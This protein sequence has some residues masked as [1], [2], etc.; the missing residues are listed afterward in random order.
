MILIS[1]MFSF[2]SSYIFFYDI[3]CNHYLCWQ[4]FGK[5]LNI[6]TIIAILSD[7]IVSTHLLRFLHPFDAIVSALTL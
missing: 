5:S 1:N 6:N 2:T 4:G 3:S 7:N